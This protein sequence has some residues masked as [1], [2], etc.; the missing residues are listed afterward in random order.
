MA[1]GG[2]NVGVGVKVRVGVD[3]KV[4]VGVGVLVRVGVYVGVWADI[5]VESLGN[6]RIGARCL[7]IE[8]D[9]SSLN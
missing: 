3:V 8:L 1:P 4:L 9:A 5:A 2:T 7:E 6:K